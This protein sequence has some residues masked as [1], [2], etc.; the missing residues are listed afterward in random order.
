MARDGE[1]ERATAKGCS[2]STPKE[3][4]GGD[5]TK[6]LAAMVQCS[7]AFG[8]DRL[9]PIVCCSARSICAL[10]KSISMTCGDSL[11]DIYLIVN[12]VYIEYVS[13]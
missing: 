9:W 8:T 6:M 5:R 7:Q 4:G 12:N 10:Q 3:E 13:D 11:F 1:K 2:K